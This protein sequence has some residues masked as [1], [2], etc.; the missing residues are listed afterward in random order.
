VPG[1]DPAKANWAEVKQSLGDGTKGLENAGAKL[2]FARD[3]VQASEDRSGSEIELL[4]EELDDVASRFE[5]LRKVLDS[6]AGPKL[7]P[8]E[9]PE[10]DPADD[11]DDG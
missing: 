4:K 5:D 8:E 2:A 9:K 3:L 10:D 7:E 11:E 6:Q 1:A